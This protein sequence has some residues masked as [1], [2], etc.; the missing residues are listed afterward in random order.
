VKDLKYDLFSAFSAAKLGIS[1]II[2]YDM[3][4]GKNHSYTIDKTTGEIT[5]LIERGRGILELPL[6]RE[7]DMNLLTADGISKPKEE[8]ELSPN[9]ISI[10]W[11]TIEKENFDHTPREN[12][13]TEFSLFTFDILRSLNQR[14]QDFLIHAR[15]GHIPRKK[16]LQLIKNGTT[17][18]ESYSGKFKELCK[19]CMQAKHRAENHGHAHVRHPEG[20]PGEHLHSDLAVV[21]TP[22]LNGNKYV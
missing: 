9:L 7:M 11:N 18:I 5:P 16:I 19:P 17:G 15:L 1:S 10:F 14:E 3:A 2:D 13:L 8:N 21:S 4:T 6:H 20:K 12:N 22:D